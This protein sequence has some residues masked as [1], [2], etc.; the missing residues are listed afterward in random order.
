MATAISDCRK[1][2][3]DFASATGAS[4]V[5]IADGGMVVGGD[6]CKAIA[7]GADAVMIGSPLAK[8]KEAPG[9][10]FHWGMATTSPVLPRGTRIKVGTE[11]TLWNLVW[12]G[13]HR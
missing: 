3:D 9:L 8:A 5:I 12:T 7:L 13:A 6:I 10:G 4:C 2:A 11:G 1:A